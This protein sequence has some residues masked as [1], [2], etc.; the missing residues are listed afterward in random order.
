MRWLL[1]AVAV[2]GCMGAVGSPEAGMNLPSPADS[3]QPQ[4]LADGSGIVFQSNLVTHG[5]DRERLVVSVTAPGLRPATS[6]DE[7]GRPVDHSPDGARVAYIADQNLF[8]K[9]IKGTSAHALTTDGQ[10]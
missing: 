8:V 5:Y 1:V 3:Q 2:A 10:A 7:P 6:A 9:D 4:W